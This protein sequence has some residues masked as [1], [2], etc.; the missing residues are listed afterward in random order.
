MYISYILILYFALWHLELLDQVNLRRK[1]SPNDCREWERRTGRPIWYADV[2]ANSSEDEGLVSWRHSHCDVT[3]VTD[4]SMC[5]TDVLYPRSD[6]V[7]VF[8]CACC[9]TKSKRQRIFRYSFTF[10]GEISPTRFRDADD[11][12]NIRDKSCI[13]MMLRIGEIH[14]TT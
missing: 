4:Y 12:C 8:W 14:I 10:V 3:Q 13:E 1:F 7:K 5:T 9:V 11:I 2:P 6:H